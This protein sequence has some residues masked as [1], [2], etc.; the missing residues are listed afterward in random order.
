MK[1]ELHTVILLVGP[2]KSGKTTWASL[3]EKKIHQIDSKIKTTIIDV[4]KDE[5]KLLEKQYIIEES[6]E[7]VAMVDKVHQ[8]IIEHMKFPQQKELIIVDALGFHKKFQDMLKKTTEDYNYKLS[9]VAFDVSKND[10]KEIRIFKNQILPALEKKKFYPFKKWLNFHESDLEKENI[11]IE[12]LDL[13]N[14]TF[15]NQELEWAIIG[16]VHEHVDALQLLLNQMQNKHFLLLGDYLDKGN[17]TKEIIDFLEKLLIEK[18]TTTII[19][20]NHESFVARRLLNQIGS[21]PLEDEVFSSLKFLKNNQEYA[22]KFLNIYHKSIPFAYYKNENFE[23][24]ATHAPC[25]LKYL[26][27]MN[28]LGQKSQRNFYFSHR[29]FEK[30]QEDL[31]FLEKDGKKQLPFHVFGH[32]AHQMDI[33]MGNK[34]WL[35]TGAVYGGYLTAM[36][37]GSEKPEFIQVKSSA[38]TEGELFYFQKKNQLKY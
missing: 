19:V 15:L 13:W 11:E 36:I 9:V 17:Q 24:Y 20:G 22:N 26:G 35:D 31:I 8:K 21:I 3:F 1:L 14:K 12:N 25:H 28:Q 29:E 5:Q 7:Y 32:V 37:L 33:E 6:P 34:I 23:L 18:P 10:N 27:K 4:E 16:D 38:L 30:M 2:R